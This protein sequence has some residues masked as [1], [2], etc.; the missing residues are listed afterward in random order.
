[1]KRQNVN[2]WLFFYRLNTFFKIACLSI[3]AFESSFEDR[4][5]EQPVLFIFL[6]LSSYDGDKDGGR[7]E[8]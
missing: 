2:F 6:P 7:M 5:H 3:K 8:L 4:L 1:M